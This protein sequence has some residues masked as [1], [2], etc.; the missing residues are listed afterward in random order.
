MP[1]ALV[2][3]VGDVRELWP[4]LMAL[5]VSLLQLQTRFGLQA[6]ISVTNQPLC[7]VGLQFGGARGSSSQLHM[8]T[9]LALVQNDVR[10]MATAQVCTHS[11]S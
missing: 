9:R 8:P 4:F 3:V 7:T 1:S 5:V 10:C 2:F 11:L 6:I